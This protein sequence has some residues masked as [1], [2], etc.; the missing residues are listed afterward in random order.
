[1]E[2]H[3]L[4]SRFAVALG[5]G[6][7]IGLERG[8]RAR[9]KESGARAAGIRTFAVSGLLGA[10]VAALAQSVGTGAGFVLG[11]GFAAFAA[12]VTVFCR[13]EN[14]A[15]GTFSATT[16]IAAIVT[17]S[18]GGYALVGDMRVAAA[19]AVATAGILAAREDIHG[20]VA[21][22]TWPE[23]RSALVLMAM[24]FI[25][26]PVV[27]GD[28]IGPF[29][30]VNPREIWLIAIVLA[31]VSFLGYIGVR[32][33][34]AQQGILIS[35]AAGGLAS[36]TAVTVANARHAAAGD[37]TPDLLAAGVS[38][39]TAVSF[40]RVLA[41]VAALQASLLWLIA[42]PLL[43]ATGVTI[44]LS[45]LPLRSAPR[46]NK[47]PQ[48]AVFRNPFAFW[49]VVGF[50]IFLGVIVV[51]GRVISERVGATGVILG[52]AAMGL[53]DVD[54]ITVSIARLAPQTLP[55]QSAAFAVLSAVATNMLSKMLIGT[56]LG[57]RAFALYLAAIS[58]AT[59]AA[60]GIALWLT[61]E[62]ATG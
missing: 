29:G 12:A 30:G 62:M 59:F 52:A 49:S 58:T 9:E 48:R 34:G 10:V 55:Q 46:R 43:A 53:A 37:A 6:L 5:I 19:A 25:V 36:S 21:R 13:E 14:R 60:A 50:A 38:L 33:L 24:T 18:L 1:M 51:A 27:P 20:W 26:L 57:S 56:V 2:P 3:D 45:L 31:G 8:W 32:V 61:L 15:S 17:F 22:I 47:L 42:P 35:G 16:A 44:A 7:L 41:I 54:A 23:L 40:L 4:L 11:F 28:P 39:A